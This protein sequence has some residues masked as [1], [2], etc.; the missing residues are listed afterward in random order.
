MT[1][2]SRYGIARQLYAV[3]ILLICALAAA[4]WLAWTQ[5]SNV[6]QL[7][8]ATGETRVPQLTRIASTELSITQ[9][10]LQIRHAMLVRSPEALKETL[11]DI[12]TKY[13]RIA[14]NDAAFLSELKD[15]RAREDFTNV[16]QKLEQ[17]FKPIADRNLRLVVEGRKDEAFEVL[18]GETIPTRNRLLAWLAKERQRQTDLLHSELAAIQKEAFKTRSQLSLLVVAIAAGLLAF[19]WYIANLLQRRVEQSRGVAE[20]VRDGDLT[21]P[22]VDTARDEF[23]PL[24]GALGDMQQAL[25]RVVSTVR[26]GS[27]SV[28]T[29]SAEIAQGNNDLSARTEQQASAL[30]ETAASMDELGAT[31]RQNADNAQQASQFAQAASEVAARGGEV[32]SQVVDTMRGIDRSSSKI[33]EII[34]VIDGIAF[35]TNILALNA[36]VEAARAGEQGR[37]FA[38]VASEVRS[39][40]Q[41]SAGAAR[42]IKELITASVAQVQSGTALVDRAG[43]TMTEVVD[44]I[45]RVTDVVS[46]ISIASREQSAGVSQVGEAVTQMDQATQQN[47]ALVEQSAA[48][49]NALRSQAEQL[50]EAVAV[51]R[52]GGPAGGAAPRLQRLPQGS[53]ARLGA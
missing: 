38:V 18:V 8:E 20:R 52:V 22:V 53:F 11:A 17:E 6:G 24:L 31:V 34:G 47:A 14:D 29:A 48:A 13:K 46:E 39:L 32:V 51:F 1:V 36:A 37:G 19:S 27:D 49:A 43:A 7:A 23:S 12:D 44:S 33:A 2:F 10:S 41:R 42:E 26:E 3:S 28:A 21:V 9:I 35:Q 50:V 4:A 40:A 30:E 45:R 16:W 25:T 15:P 5:L